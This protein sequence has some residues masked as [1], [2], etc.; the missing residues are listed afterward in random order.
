MDLMISRI[1]TVFYWFFF[2]RNNLVYQKVSCS[3]SK[4][5]KK[6]DLSAYTQFIGDFT[7]SAEVADKVKQF[8]DIGLLPTYSNETAKIIL[9]NTM[10]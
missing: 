1:G 5:R 7:F 9:G 8:K 2:R 6:S 4:F 3:L 10:V